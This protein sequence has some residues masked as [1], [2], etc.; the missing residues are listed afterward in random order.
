M[1]PLSTELNSISLAPSV[2]KDV[3]LGLY[4]SLVLP[5]LDYADVV[6]DC[7]NAKDC[8]EIQKLQNYAVRIINMAGYDKSTKE[9]HIDAELM[10]L[11]DRR[12]SHTITYV[13]KGINGLLPEGVARQLTPVNTAHN[14]NTRAAQRSDLTI[15]AYHLDM[16]RRAFRHR[17]PYFWNMMEEGV[18]NE[19]S[20][21]NFKDSLKKSDMFAII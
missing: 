9:M 20:V 5:V 11:S 6:Y 13:Y 1:C 2:G 17:G 3:T 12:H 19:T 10:Y 8:R 21:K 4:K 18:R 14:L 15:P 7:L 16:T